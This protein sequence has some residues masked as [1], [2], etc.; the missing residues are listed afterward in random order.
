MPDPSSTGHETPR[1]PV[2]WLL[3][4]SFTTGLVDAISVIGLDKVFT[5]NMTG[6]IVF[7]G[8]G[9]AG[10]AGFHV[11][12]NLVSIVGFVVGAMVAGRIGRGFGGQIMQRWRF[13]GALTEIV[14]LWTAAPAV[15]WRSASAQWPVPW[16]SAG[17][18]SHRCWRRRGC[19]DSSALRPWR[20]I[21]IPHGPSRRVDLTSV[22]ARLSLS[23]GLACIRAHRQFFNPGVPSMPTYVVT[24]P[25]ARLAPGQK[26]Q[27]AAAITDIHCSVATALP[28]F[29][30]VIFNDVPEGNYFVGGKP[31]K[32]A[33]HVFVHGEIREGRSGEIRENWCSS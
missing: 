9:V 32:T 13:T 10:A 5:A 33:D 7:L 30:Q 23:G 26:Q 27:I 2:G 1:K 28:C 20:C 18:G 22:T 21:R 14:L 31:L 19:W 12:P 17:S 24:A 3:L 16:W 25:Q 11:A 4:L 6:N 29:A 15:C 8:F